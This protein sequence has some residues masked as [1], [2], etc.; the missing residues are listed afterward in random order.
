MKS[1]AITIDRTQ[2]T[3]TIVLQLDTARPSKATGKTMLIAST[4]GL[5]TSKETYARRPV[6]FTANVLYFP[7]SPKNSDR[8]H[9]GF[10]REREENPGRPSKRRAKRNKLDE[11]PELRGSLPDR[12]AR[13]NLIEIPNK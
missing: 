6:Y 9:R 11:E 10:N 4:R 1:P 13:R 12:V 5:R 7:T 8:T 2:K 3:V